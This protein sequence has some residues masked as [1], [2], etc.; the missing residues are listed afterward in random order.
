MNNELFADCNQENWWFFAVLLIEKALAAIVTSSV[1]G[2]A[3]PK[4]VCTLTGVSLLLL[5][6]RCVCV[7]AALPWEKS[8]S[9]SP[10]PEGTGI[11][12]AHA[13]SSRVPNILE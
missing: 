8:S 1:Q 13:T 3:K 4:V 2:P 12:P 7:V 10:E 9:Q 11:G 6:W 5:L